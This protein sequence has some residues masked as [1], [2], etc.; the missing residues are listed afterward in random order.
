[1]VLAAVV[2]LVGGSAYDFN[3]FS[4]QVMGRATTEM[5]SATSSA[6]SNSSTTEYVT[7]TNVTET[8]TF[9]IKA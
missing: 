7:G 4:T 6:L 2:V 9:F 8:D 5:P 1:M 3:A